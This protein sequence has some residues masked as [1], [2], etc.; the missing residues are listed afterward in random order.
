M[1]LRRVRVLRKRSPF[2]YSDTT[3]HH[4]CRVS[5]RSWRCFEEREEEIETSRRYFLS[6]VSVLLVALS[7][8]DESPRMLYDV[9]YVTCRKDAANLKYCNIMAYVPVTRCVNNNLLSDD[10]RFEICWKLL[11]SLSG[12]EAS[13]ESDRCGL[14]I[15]TSATRGSRV[16]SLLTVTSAECVR[17][18]VSVGTSFATGW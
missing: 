17:R 3:T 2:D 5:F 7:R 8:D 16:D 15:H 1:T 14:A 18:D 13:V 9:L 6:F 10:C 4:C 11:L 12:L